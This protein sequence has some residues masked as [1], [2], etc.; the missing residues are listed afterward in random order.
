MLIAAMQALLVTADV[1]E[2]GDQKYGVNAWMDN[3]KPPE[4]NRAAHIA[5]LKRHLE[6]LER[7]EVID[8]SGFPTLGHIAARTL[9]ALHFDEQIRE[10]HREDRD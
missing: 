4:E 3:G 5:G 7:G 10:A 8:E 9:M 6:R 2:H 1:M